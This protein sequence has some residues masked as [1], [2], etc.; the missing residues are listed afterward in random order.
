MRNPT[1]DLTLPVVASLRKILRSIAIHSKQLVKQHQLTHPQLIVLRELESSP[2]QNLSELARR[3]KLSNPTVTGIV[4]R[5]EKR[6]LVA[7]RRSSTDRRQVRI[8]ITDTGRTALQNA[9]RPL[10]D[11]F[12]KQLEN[13]PAYEQAQLLASLER[14]ASM[15]NA[16]SLEAAPLLSAHP[17]DADETSVL[18]AEEGIFTAS[19]AQKHPRTLN[20]YDMTAL[21]E[22]LEVVHLKQPTDFPEWLTARDLAEFLFHALKPYNDTLEDILSGINDALGAGNGGFIVVLHENRVPKGALVMLNTGMQGYV[23]PHLLLFV[24]VDPDCR[25]Q[26]LGRWLITNA[27]SHCEGPIAL[28]VEYDNPAKRLYERV[29]FKSKYAEMRYDR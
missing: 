27:A 25:G 4:D 26:G 21:P 9:P 29:G 22:S 11:H 1:P 17:L 7:R 8:N 10:Q 16:E 12:V 23:P 24:A 18:A 19:P 28:H 14:V 20:T 3:V 6:E 15:M 5:L 13:L 2:V